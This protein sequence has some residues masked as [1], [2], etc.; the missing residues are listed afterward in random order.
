MPRTDVLLL[1]DR[2]PKRLVVRDTAE[3]SSATRMFSVVA[4]YDWAERILF[5]GAYERDA[6]DIASV[7]GD[8]LGVPVVLPT[9]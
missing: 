9:A 3:P 2:S 8:A 5:A 1:D 4:D 7:L 6:V